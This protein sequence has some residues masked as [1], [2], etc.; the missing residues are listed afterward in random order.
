MDLQITNHLYPLASK[1]KYKTL[2]S[3]C[4]AVKLNPKWVPTRR[5]RM[6]HT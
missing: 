5:C 6:N 3:Q 4:Q 2:L 1:D